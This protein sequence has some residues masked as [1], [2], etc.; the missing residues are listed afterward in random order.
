M[1]LIEKL[2]SIDVKDLK[3]LDYGKLLKE[4]QR[5]PDILIGAALIAL[6]FFFSVSY[7]AKHKTQLKNIRVEILQLE[8]KIQ[9]I[10]RYNQTK[11]DLDEF[12]SYIHP[13]VNETDF[14]NQIT[15]YAAKRK[16][17]IGSLSPSRKEDQALAQLTKVQMHLVAKTYDALWLFIYD[18]EKSPQYFRID[19]WRGEMG[20]T[21]RQ[22]RVDRSATPIEQDTITVDME[23]T[24]INFKN[25]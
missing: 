25:E 11:A 9:M 12:L 4:A 13:F 6:T 7:F 18:I 14:I 2:N 5:S 19:S 10:E 17:Q 24:L 23:I 1:G 21:T 16:I 8:D 3:Q 15:D 22:R 20:A